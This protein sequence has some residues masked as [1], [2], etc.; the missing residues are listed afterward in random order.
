MRKYFFLGL[1]CQVSLIFSQSLTGVSGLFKTPN[2]KI[3]MDGEGFIGF[4]FYPKTT[5]NLFG[6]S[7][8]FNG[9]PSYVTMG[10]F[11]V[12]EIS[13]R[14]T[15]QLGQVTNIDT[16]YFPDRMFSSKIN[17]L[18]EGKNLPSFS[19]GIHDLTELFS[20]SSA[21]PWFFASY[22]VSTKSLEFGNFNSAVTVGYGFDFFHSRELV[23]DG[24][25]GGI[26]IY[27]SYLPYIKLIAE[28]DSA[29]WNTAIK[30][31]FPPH[32][33]AAIGFL[34]GRFVTGFVGL[35]FDLHK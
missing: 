30:L 24:V 7:D 16:K 4:S 15:H 10:F 14:Y 32:F 21:A 1:F 34:Q 31:N 28:Y 35:T 22:F 3:L 17:V 19:V 33:N 2:S 27:S 12:V 29:F 13:F 5:Y 20:A 11:D 18:R 8:D 6:T 25:F 9:M 23:F 26:E